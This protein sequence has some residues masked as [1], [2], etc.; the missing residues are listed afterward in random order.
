MFEKVYKIFIFTNHDAGAIILP[1][2]LFAVSRH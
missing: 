1:I 2:L